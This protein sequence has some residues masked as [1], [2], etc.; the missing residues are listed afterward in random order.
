LPDGP[1]PTRAE[2]FDPES[3]TRGVFKKASVPLQLADEKSGVRGVLP[4]RL[5]KL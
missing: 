3:L 1:E 5:Q 2:T 4:N